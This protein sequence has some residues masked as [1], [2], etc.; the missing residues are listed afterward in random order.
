MRKLTCLLPL[1]FLI[2]GCQSVPSSKSVV[3]VSATPLRLMIEPLLPPTHHI[4]TITPEN[5]E[6]HHFEP[7]LQDR[8]KIENSELF[9]YYGY[10][11]D[12][13]ANRLTPKNSI[14]RLSSHQEGGHGWLNPHAARVLTNTVIEKLSHQTSFNKAEILKRGEEQIHNLESLDESYRQGLRT[15]QS[16]RVI[17]AHS[18]L[19]GLGRAYGF[20]PVALQGGGHDEEPTLAQ[21][22]KVISLIKSEK[23]TALLDDGSISAQAIKT[24]VDQTGV[25]ILPFSSMERSAKNDT[26][27]SI[28][29]ANLV[30]LRRAM[31]CQ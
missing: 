14:L 16:H 25:M 6:P 15:C 1:L 29:E 11:L 26:Y 28:L 24:L 30:A 31:G 4:V 5:V 18:G 27:I 22:D 19:E 8:D 13:W 3:T 20:E 9:I 2:L 10:E 12:E 17:V 21:L 23:I 7:T